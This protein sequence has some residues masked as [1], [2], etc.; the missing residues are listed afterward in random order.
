MFQVIEETISLTASQEKIKIKEY[1]IMAKDI[2]SLTADK[3][4]YNDANDK[5]KTL[6]F[7]ASTLISYNGK[8]YY[9]LSDVSMAIKRGSYKGCYTRKQHKSKRCYDSGTI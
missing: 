5:E 8:P 2:V 3:I 9:E 6:T 4:V 1:D 7:D